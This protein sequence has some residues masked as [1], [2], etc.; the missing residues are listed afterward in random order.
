[1]HR[2]RHAAGMEVPP[3]A[4]DRWRR[5]RSPGCW[6]LAIH[7]A[8]YKGRCHRPMC[9]EDRSGR[10]R[11]KKARGQSRRKPNSPALPVR[12]HGRHVRGFSAYPGV[13]CP[14]QVKISSSCIIMTLHDNPIFFKRRKRRKYGKSGIM[15]RVSIHSRYCACV[16]LHWRDCVE[17]AY[18]KSH[19]DGRACLT[20]TQQMRKVWTPADQVVPSFRI[21]VRKSYL[22]GR[23]FWQLPGLQVERVPAVR[24]KVL[25]IELRAGP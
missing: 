3:K 10:A 25:V 17:N 22:V 18:R 12:N 15:R 13:G 14:R 23:F 9:T 21:P 20:V 1:M 4:P 5:R 8:G 16:I 7:Q 24:P 11:F 19:M 6:R 2:C